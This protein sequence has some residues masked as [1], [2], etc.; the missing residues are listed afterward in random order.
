MYPPHFNLSCLTH[1]GGGA[2]GGERGLNHGSWEGGVLAD[3]GVIV[4]SLWACLRLATQAL[5]TE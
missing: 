5:C 1:S 3:T 4:T 2:G